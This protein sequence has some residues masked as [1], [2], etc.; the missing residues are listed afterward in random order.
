[1][2]DFP[3]FI[4]SA[5]SYSDLWP[6]FFELFERYWPGYQGA[7]YLNTE[8]KDFYRAGLDIRCTK[9]GK[10]GSFGKTFRAGLEKVE[11]ETL[12]L[13]MIDYFIMGTVDKDALTDYYRL[14]N[15]R[16]LDSLCL[17]RN[18][19]RQS[20]RQGIRDLAIVVPPSND[21][22]S[23]QI[24][25]WKKKTLVEMA[26]PHE[27]PWLSEWYGTL[28]ANVMKIK[29]GFVNGPLVIPYI[30]EGALHK[31]K[32]VPPMVDFLNSIDYKVDF[33]KRGFFHGDSQCLKSRIKGRIQTF[34]PRCR[35]NFDLALRYMGQK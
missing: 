35:S 1:M 11:S 32:W 24:A 21:M 6:M 10:L 17:C 2:C 23:Y 33:E 27:T 16:Q 19:Y 13:S 5:D 30:A 28:R 9:V 34:W 12:L 15:E 22:F 29:L 25:F 7:I 18:P 14:F 31:G 8:E 20:I 4:S 26:L 3:I